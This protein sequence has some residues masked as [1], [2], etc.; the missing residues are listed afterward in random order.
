MKIWDT[1]GKAHTEETL[2]I[3]LEEAKKLS[4]KLLVATT[5]GE[6]ALAALQ[7]AKAAGQLDSL[8]I[9][10]HAF[11]TREPGTNRMPQETFAALRAEGV[12][13]VTAAHALSGAER[14]LSSKFG[15]V[16][17]AEIIAHTLRMFSQG[18][19]VAVEI[20][21]M[22][23]DAG[24]IPH[25]KPCVALGGTGRGADTAAVLL[26]AHSQDILSTKVVEMLCKPG[27]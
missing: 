18:T 15:G 3:G 23:L 12:P 9:I 13:I 17:P 26:P 16:Y 11:G 19:K 24:A 5:T 8:V 21:A 27:V 4:A 6:T 7:A 14:G 2:R 1:A 22:A 25:G 10:S 20:A